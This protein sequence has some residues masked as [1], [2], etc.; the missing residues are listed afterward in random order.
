M[1]RY[2]QDVLQASAL[3][4]MYLQPGGLEAF[5]ADNWLVQRHRE[6]TGVDAAQFYE[7]IYIHRHDKVKW[8][9]DC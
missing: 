6:H 5:L 9:E 1:M 3:L 2:S 7:I 4:L 8:N